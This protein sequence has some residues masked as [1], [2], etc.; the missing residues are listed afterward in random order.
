M[1]VARHRHQLGQAHIE[2]RVRQRGDIRLQAVHC[3]LK[4]GLR[5]LRKEERI[6][7]GQLRGDETQ[8]LRAAFD[9][10]GLGIRKKRRQD[11]E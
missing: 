4:V 9:G 3:P 11:K 1:R 6:E 2:L 5:K 8:V 7:R 10:R